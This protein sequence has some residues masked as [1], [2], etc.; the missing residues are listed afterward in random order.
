MHSTFYLVINVTKN[1]TLI[2][3]SPLFHP[4]SDFPKR[5]VHPSPNLRFTPNLIQI[6][7]KLPYFRTPTVSK[8]PAHAILGLASRRLQP[9]HFIT[10]L[11]ICRGFKFDILTIELTP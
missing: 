3:P 2:L 10:F 9:T 11:D 8:N 4:E 5:E 7:S 6:R 1:V